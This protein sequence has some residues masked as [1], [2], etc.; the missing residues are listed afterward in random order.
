MLPGPLPLSCHCA[1]DATIVV[2][3]YTPCITYLF[4]RVP[5]GVGGGRQPFLLASSPGT[6]FSASCD[7]FGVSTIRTVGPLGEW[8]AFS[9][10]GVVQREQALFLE[11]D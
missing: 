9:W 7:A 6:V 5:A 1:S 10:F 11:I 4:A 3:P 8:M 2:P